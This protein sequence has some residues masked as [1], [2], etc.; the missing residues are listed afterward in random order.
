MNKLENLV[1]DIEEITKETTENKTKVSSRQEKF[2]TKL[3]EISGLL[4][5]GAKLNQK[6]LESLAESIKRLPKEIKLDKVTVINWP[7][8]LRIGNLKDIPLQTKVEVKEPKW[9]KK[10]QFGGILKSIY[11]TV[12][13]GI[14]DVRVSNKKPIDVQLVHKNFKYKGSGGGGAASG[15]PSAFKD[16]SGNATRGVINSRGQLKVVLDGRV[17]TENS[18]M[19]PL[20]AGA[21]YQGSS[22]DTL[23]YA[24]IFITVFSNVGSATDGL[25]TEI[26]SDGIVWRDGDVFTVPAGSEK[27]YSFQ[28][29][30]RYF[31]VKYTNGGTIQGIFDLQTVLK[32]NNSKASSHRIQDP[33]VDEDDAELMKSVL[34]GLSDINDT[35][36]NVR[37]YR[38]A[39]QVDAALVHR[40]G[41]SE[42]AKRDLGA[43]TTLDVAASS[44]D[45]LINVASTVGFAVDD[46]VRISNTDIVERSHFHITVVD[47]G[48]SLTLNRPIDND[49][50]VGDDV[51]EIQIGMNVVGSLAAPISFKVQPPSNERWQITRMMTTMLDDSAMD[52][53]KFG[54]LNALANGVAI[55]VINDGATRTLTHW[56][57]NADLKDDMYD[58]TYSSKAPAGQ[59]GLSSRWTFTKGEFVV[60]L[61]G[62]TGDYMEVLVQDALNGLVDFEVKAQ[63]RLFGE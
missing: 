1:N 47:P 44:G 63:G 25:V 18:T 45:T 30:K 3:S 37:T 31:R 6:S 22:V 16:E 19:T 57:S 52:D 56:K 34:T 49:L 59:H 60:D 35:F 27:T 40:V 8:E 14:I 28:P 9:L 20:L 24:L 38:G 54:G 21:T 51:T 7:D 53:G 5:D 62:A 46:L 41:I 32:K 43:T 11:K 55:R 15:G 58:V 33:I 2:N 23:D 39:L 13:Q 50:E 36:E 12:K 29:N 48:V 17:S 10:L 4:A 26:S 42:H 61:D